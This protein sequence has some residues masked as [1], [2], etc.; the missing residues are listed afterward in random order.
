[1]SMHRL[2]Y[3]DVH[4]ETEILTPGQIKDIKW[5]LQEHKNL[6]EKLK[7]AVDALT[8]VKKSLEVDYYDARAVLADWENEH[9]VI[10]EAL[11][12]IGEL[13]KIII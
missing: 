3:F 4:L 10:T 11:K 2:E 9:E 12:E 5:L 7:I 1:M 8:K 13:W 6:T